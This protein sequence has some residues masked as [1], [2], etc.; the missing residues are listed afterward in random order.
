[1]KTDLIIIGS[2]P[3]GYKAA[4]Y[5]AKKE[6]TVVV[7]EGAY[8]GG[9]CLNCG[10]IPT[11][12]FCH[13][14]SLET[15]D[16]TKATLR[17]NEVVNM[18]RNGV[19]QLM[20]APG[21]T[22]IKGWA[23]L[24]DSH[25][26]ICVT[27]SSEETYTADYIII[28]TG[29]KAK[30]LPI[31]GITS[32]NVVT[33]T[34]LLN[35]DF[36]PKNLVIV[37]AGVIGLEFASIFNRFG[38]T[39][40]VVEFM[41]ECLPAMDTDIAKRLR[42]SLEKQG[43]T[44]YMQAGVK[45]INEQNVIF[46]RKGKDVSIPADIV[47]IATGRQANTDGLCLDAAGIEE[48]K[49]GIIVD[50]N[51][52]TNVNNIFAIGDVNGKCLL[53]HAATMQGIKAV[54]NILKEK[55]ID[56]TDNI[57]LDIMPAAVFTTPEAAGVGYTEEQCKQ[58]GLD[59]RCLKSFYRANGKALSMN[60]TDGIVKLIINS[61]NR[62]IGAHVLGP[63]AADIVQEVTVLMNFNATLSQLKDIVHIHPTL[64]ET[65]HDVQDYS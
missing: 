8:A 46:E 20:A 45:T 16:F 63:H 4:E 59:Y 35:I 28:A 39:V 10:C 61:D 50:E 56:A 65:L 6:L 47:L 30:I 9:T 42:K 15:K 60:E 27:D 19:E 37:G 29:S 14:A 13:E 52:R 18:L 2:G 7:F 55:G 11:K 40:T 41:K 5:A 21:I 38:S 12:T 25:T 17:K 32:P 62:I 22:F 36:V 23:R 49:T 58:Q 31:D 54:N 53:A 57:R 26:V 48:S 51:M 24:A 1:M 64:S 33:S 44:F 3:G 34:E 43:I